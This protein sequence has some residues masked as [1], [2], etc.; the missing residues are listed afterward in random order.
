[1]SDDL[2]SVIVDFKADIEYIG[3]GINSFEFT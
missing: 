1:M 2:S 3:S